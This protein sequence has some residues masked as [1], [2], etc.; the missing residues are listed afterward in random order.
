MEHVHYAKDL[1]DNQF[2]LSNEL[3][4]NIKADLLRLRTV[5]TKTD[6]EKRLENRFELIAIDGLDH[7]IKKR[8][9]PALI[10]YYIISV[11]EA[12]EA[13]LREHVESGEYICIATVHFYFCIYTYYLFRTCRTA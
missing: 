12:Y 11:E 8:K 5:S 7:L 4:Q 3:V 13:I 2:L 1:K 6:R 9:P 10:N